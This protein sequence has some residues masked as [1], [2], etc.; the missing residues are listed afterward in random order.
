M[1]DEE[2][3]IRLPPS[4]TLSRENVSPHGAY[5]LDDGRRLLLWLGE[6]V[7][8]KL[9]EELFDIDPSQPNV[10]PS[11][12]RVSQSSALRPRCAPVKD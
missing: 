9:L 1:P 10:H 2:G 8:G 6:L 4:L 7:D 5:L 12:L 11:H 3:C